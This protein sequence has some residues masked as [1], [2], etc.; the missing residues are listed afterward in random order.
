M[1]K[2]M[3]KKVLES[4]NISSGM[5]SYLLEY[6][7][8]D[9][10]KKGYLLVHKGQ[11]CQ[12]AWFLV[13]GLA[14]SRYF[15]QNGKQLITRFWKENQIILA[16][17]SFNL[18]LPAAEDIV[19]LE[20]CTLLSVD[21]R[22]EQHLG[23]LFAETQSLARQIHLADE[24]QNQLR[25]HLLTLST[26]QAYGLF[27]KN[28]DANRFQLQDIGAYLNRTPQSISRIRRSSLPRK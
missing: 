5:S 21:H 10:H 15:D 22:Q 16:K 23:S 11:I 8:V 24:R 18:P 2:E 19:L 25:S 1:K 3:I 6:A 9:S 17:E 13:K 14:K 4:A 27:C 7:R 28:F 20:N 12:R 26:A